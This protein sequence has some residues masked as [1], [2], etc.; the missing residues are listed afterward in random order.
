M[1]VIVE[2]KM[3]KISIKE[4]IDQIKDNNKT[5]SV[6]K[7]LFVLFIYLTVIISFIVAIN[8]GFL[9]VLGK[10]SE[11]V[12]FYGVLLFMFIIIIIVQPYGFGYNPC[13]IIVG[14][15]YGWSGIFIVLLSTLVGSSVAFVLVR[16]FGG[17][18]CSNGLEQMSE[19]QQLFLRELTRVTSERSV[20]S[21][22]IM[23][24]LRL[25]PFPFGVSNLLVCL[26]EVKFVD[27]L[28]GLLLFL[29]VDSPLSI[30][31]GIL[32]G[33][34]RDLFEEE[35]KNETI[36]EEENK[37]T[38]IQIGVSTGLTIIFVLIGVFY[39]R[40]VWKTI[41]KQAEQQ[42]QNTNEQEE[43]QEGEEGEVV[44]HSV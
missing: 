31:L 44:F 34:S 5:K 2:E 10:F 33:Q 20:K 9:E 4:D 8:K 17:S 22:F 19:K 12:G 23:V 40:Y 11:D 18:C 14:F 26:T 32:I 25:S 13:V 28:V 43:Q 1:S 42:K 36:S 41:S 16:K 30:N 15:L 35:D 21:Y 7:K 24:G 39:G 27:F 37:F 3:S 29:M 6:L 38:N